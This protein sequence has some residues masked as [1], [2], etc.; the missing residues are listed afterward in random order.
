MRTPRLKVL[1]TE[2]N[3]DCAHSLSLTYPFLA[4]RQL[5]FSISCNRAPSLLESFPSTDLV[6][7][8]SAS[9]TLLKKKDG[10]SVDHDLPIDRRDTARDWLLRHHPTSRVPT[11]LGFRVHVMSR[12]GP[13]LECELI[14]DKRR[15]QIHRFPYALCSL[16]CS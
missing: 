10:H 4:Q 9:V 1:F 2:A 5:L 14:K 8:L 15:L 3:L 13:R 16:R 11:G 12:D 7:G 6:P